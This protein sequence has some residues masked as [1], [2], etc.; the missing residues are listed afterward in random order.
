MNAP[1]LEVRNL[2]VQ[3]KTDTGLT[4]ALRNVSFDVPRGEV[5]AIVG[6]SGS[7]KSVTANC[8]MRLIAPPGRITGGSVR[9]APNAAE[10][11]DI[12]ALEDRD[13]RLRALR[14]GHISMVFQEPMTALSPVH[15][16]GGQVAE[17]ILCHRDAS[18]AE[19]WAEAAQMLRQVGIGDIERRMKMYPFEFSGGMRQRVVIATA[20]VCRPEVLICDEPTTALDVTIQ[21]EI[22][23]LIRRLQSELGNS[24]VFIT[25]DLGVVAQI[26]DHVVVMYQGRVLEIGTVRQVLKDPLHPYTKGLL[27][28]IPGVVPPGER[29]ATIAS[30][31]GDADLATPFPLL[32]LAD[33]RQVS[34]PPAQVPAALRP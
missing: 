27:K 1:V 18:K 32:R 9:F 25:H 23:T 21:A 19:A 7:G 12:V 11:F 17:A 20:L 14:G 15:D 30:V 24:V 16:I 31:V 13:P 33:G 29:L 5:T 3:F 4:H 26:A 2:A 8:I 28:A 6:E 10:A 34:L 22:L